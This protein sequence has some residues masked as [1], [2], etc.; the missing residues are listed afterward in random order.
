MISPVLVKGKNRE[1]LEILSPATAIV[2]NGFYINWA[3]N[4]QLELHLTLMDDTSLAYSL[5]D[6]ESSI[7]FE[8]QEY[9]IKQCIPN[10]NNGVVTKEIVA[11]HI[12]SDISRIRIYKINF[13]TLTYSIQD[14]LDFYLN[15]NDLGYTYQVYGN[16]DKRQITDLGNGSGSDM[17]SQIISTWEDA[18]IWPDNK[19]IRIYK[20]EAFYKNYNGRIDYMRDAPN[21]KISKD[22]TTLCNSIMCYGKRNNDNSS[23][24]FKPFLVEDEESIAKWGRFPGDDISDERFTD[25]KAMRNYALGKLVP[26]P[27]VMIE[28]A[29]T[30]NWKPIAGEVRRLQVL[31]D[32]STNVNIVGFTWYPFDQ[33]SATTLSLNNVPI[34]ILN[35]NVN[36]GRQINRLKNETSKV[37]LAIR[38]EIEK[39]SNNYNHQ[40]SL[41]ESR[42]SSLNDMYESQFFTSDSSETSE[43]IS[44]SESMLGSEV[45]D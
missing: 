24:V 14:V 25:V 7:L 9:K 40:Q 32:F 3:L 29:S 43:S 33:N 4:Q 5:A 16:F 42:L 31:N 26:E 15:K 8:G 35:Q 18:I 45:S 13:G 36:L 22:S 34:S 27:I 6:I 41:I 17:L 19:I 2:W 23:Y 39:Q 37:S 28:V 44:E 21:I 38:K 30:K 10:Y 20:P 12:Y 1:E 11:V